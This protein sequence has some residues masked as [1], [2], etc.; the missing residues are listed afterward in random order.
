[1]S[2][3]LM[4]ALIFMDALDISSELMS[5]CVCSSALR[6][7]FSLPVNSR[8]LHQLTILKIVSGFSGKKMVAL[9]VAIVC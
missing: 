7:R 2:W 1:M 3:F 4:S 9:S 5:F 6:N 8:I